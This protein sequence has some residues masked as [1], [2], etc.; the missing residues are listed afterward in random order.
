MFLAVH[1]LI[2]LVRFSGIF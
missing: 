1:K 2:G